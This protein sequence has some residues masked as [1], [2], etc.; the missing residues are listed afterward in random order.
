MSIRGGGGGGGGEVGRLVYQRHIMSKL[1]G[2]H[3]TLEDIMIH[4]EDIMIHIGDITSSLRIGSS[5]AHWQA[6]WQN[7]FILYIETSDA[8][9][10]S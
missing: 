2:Y 10:I 6:H 4:M 8:L 9:N 7:T 3:E 1:E 5:S